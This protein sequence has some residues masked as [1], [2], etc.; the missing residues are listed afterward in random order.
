MTHDISRPGDDCKAVAAD[1][2]IVQFPKPERSKA[3]WAELYARHLIDQRPEVGDILVAIHE[4]RTEIREAPSRLRKNR[5]L[6][7]R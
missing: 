7:R 5:T 6:S 3:E 1:S 4:L 2:N